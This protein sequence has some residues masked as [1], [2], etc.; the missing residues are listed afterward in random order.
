[1]VHSPRSV[2]GKGAQP[3]DSRR[4]IARALGLARKTVAAYQRGAKLETVPSAARRRRPPGPPGGA[5][6]AVDRMRP[7][8]EQIATWLT[9]EHLRLAAAKPTPPGRS[10]AA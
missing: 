5:A 9:N 10:T 3:G 6:P 1:M 4:S 7:Y 2:R 8:T